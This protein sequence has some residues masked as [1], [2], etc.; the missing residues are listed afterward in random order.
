MKELNRVL[1]SF[2]F[3]TNKNKTK[4]SG[5]NNFYL[6]ND[7]V[8]IKLTIVK[9]YPKEYGL[10]LCAKSLYQN[11]SDSFYQEHK[12][13]GLNDY[14][15]P[16][17]FKNLEEFKRFIIKEIDK[18]ILIKS[19]EKLY[20][21]VNFVYE[22]NQERF[23]KNTNNYKRYN[24]TCSEVLLSIYLDL[25]EYKKAKKTLNNYINWNNTTI[26]KLNNGYI[27]RLNNQLQFIYHNIN[28]DTK[29]IVDK[30]YKEN[31]YYNNIL[32]LIDYEK[33]EDIRLLLNNIKKENELKYYEITE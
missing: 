10:S 19:S 11:I 33:Y 16:Q 1:R 15:Y 27:N 32:E 29:Y 3:K 26:E 20:Q 18:I 23:L 24:L 13:I 9:Y 12:G 17:S 25:K 14:I 31:I 4:F 8:L 21:M 28:I 2:G 30:L 7:K 6:K 22:K 5:E